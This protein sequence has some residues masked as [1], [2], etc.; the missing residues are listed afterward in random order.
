MAA[1]PASSNDSPL[2]LLRTSTNTTSRFQY[3]RYMDALG[4]GARR[5]IRMEFFKGIVAQWRPPFRNPL[6][7]NTVKQD[8][9]PGLTVED[10]RTLQAAAVDLELDGMKSLFQH[11]VLAAETGYE[12]FVPKIDSTAQ[13]VA[14]SRLDPHCASTLLNGTR[15]M[16]SAL[17]AGGWRPFL[18]GETHKL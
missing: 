7:D 16:V 10:V 11:F 2:M 17:Q 9:Y 3:S 14:G 15:H 8:Q 5:A 18:C 13:C 6:I 1:F 4:E 12:T